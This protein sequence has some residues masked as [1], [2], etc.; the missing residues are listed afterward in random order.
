MW[1]AEATAAATALDD[2]FI[3]DDGTVFSTGSDAPALLVAALRGHDD[4]TPSGRAWPRSASSA[5][6]PTPATTGA[7]RFVLGRWATWSAATRSAS[8]T[9]SERWR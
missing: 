2:L 3:D 4:A 5:C 7:N 1:L 8:A 9:C 6:R